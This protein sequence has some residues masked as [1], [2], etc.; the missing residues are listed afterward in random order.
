M[1]LSGIIMLGGGYYVYSNKE[2]PLLND[3]ML[4]IIYA[5]TA[6]GVFTDKEKEVV[7]GFADKYRVDREIVYQ[8]IDEILA[9]IDFDAETEIID[10]NKKKGDDFEKFIIK[11]FDKEKFKILQWAGD[12]YVDGIYSEKTQQPDIIVEFSYEN[13]KRT[14]AVECK[15]RN[16]AENGKIYFSYK[17]QLKRYKKFQKDENT[18]VYIALGIGGKASAPEELYLI[19]LK[20]LKDPYVSED[21]LS[22]YKK[23]VNCDFYFKMNYAQLDIQ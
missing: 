9:N 10:Q 17:D 18:D 11:K 21:K 13:Y 2:K 19:P 14:F 6:D 8:H 15:W 4:G 12:K 1:M 22:K 5:V 16:K 3:D 23:K 20:D 7:N